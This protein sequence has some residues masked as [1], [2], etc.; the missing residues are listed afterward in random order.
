MASPIYDACQGLLSLC[1]QRAVVSLWQ[2]SLASPA[3][4]GFSLDSQLCC[5]SLLRVSSPESAPV[6]FLGPDHWSLTLSTQPPLTS[7][8]IDVC[9]MLGSAGQH[10]SLCWILFCLL[11]TCCCTPLWGSK[12]LL[13]CSWEGVSMCVETFPSLCRL[14]KAQV[15]VP[16]SFVSFFSFIFYPASFC[17]DEL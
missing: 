11:S 13:V 12:V 4:T 3:G 7:G 15:L 16:N 1:W 6:L 10:W 14:P 5:I 17:E 8:H 9:F 2:W